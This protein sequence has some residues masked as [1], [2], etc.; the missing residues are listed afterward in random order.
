MIAKNAKP[1]TITEYIQT[2]PKESQEKLKEVRDCIKSAAPEALEIINYQMPTFKLNGKN[3][4]H[5]AAWKNH[6]GLYPTPSATEKFKKEIEQYKAAKGSI[7]FPLGEP[8]P[9]S[10]IRKITEFRVKEVMKKIK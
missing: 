2:A 5:F 1:K 8:L 7:Q 10:L 3:L 4:I 9:L 6:I